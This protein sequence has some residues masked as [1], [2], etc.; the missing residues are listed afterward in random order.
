MANRF[1]NAKWCRPKGIPPARLAL[2]RAAHG[3][4][5]A[6]AKYWRRRRQ[7]EWSKKA[8]K[9]EQWFPIGMILSSRSLTKLQPF[10]NSKPG[11]SPLF[12]LHVL[13]NVVATL[14]AL[15][16]RGAGHLAGKI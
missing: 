10:G 4:A 6:G 7:P 3:L 2:L 8:Q 1:L 11:P 14:R 12:R 9:R 5:T 13:D 16:F 15:D